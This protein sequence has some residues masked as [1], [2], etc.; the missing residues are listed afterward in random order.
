MRFE[1]DEEKAKAN[2]AKHGVAFDVAMQV[3]D[4]PRAVATFDRIVDREERWRT[5]GRVGTAT[6]LFVAH[7][8]L[9]EDGEICVRIISARQADKME[10]RAYERGDEGHFR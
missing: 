8:W 9:D 10:I 4:D 5:V 2:L 6:I 3:F 1:W 7:T